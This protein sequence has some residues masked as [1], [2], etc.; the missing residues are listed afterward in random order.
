MGEA[1]MTIARELFELQEIDLE[2]ESNEQAVREMTARLG[3]SEALLQARSE[4]AAAKEHL[5]E[6]GRRQRDLEG[7]IADTGAKLA[8]TEDQMY[9]G[10]TTNPKE[11]TGLQQEAGILKAK[12]SDLEDRAV[13]VI[14]QTEAAAAR[15]ADLTG[16]L[17]KLT[18]EWQAEQ[19]Q[20]K[21]EIAEREQRL[22][23]LTAKRASLAAAI[24]PAA[25]GVYHDLRKR[26]GTAVAGVEQGI[27]RGC[28]IS[29]SSAQMQRVRSGGLIECTS[30]GRILF[31]P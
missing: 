27:C 24:E 9:S 1:E 26:R 17:A 8:R 7:E 23:G 25:L 10:R 28:R 14:E 21:N 29:L 6:Q 3:E 15:T 31:L 2:I 22:A 4:L 20:L 11:L 5:E 13:E 12:R 30:C 16:R 19:Q 18:A